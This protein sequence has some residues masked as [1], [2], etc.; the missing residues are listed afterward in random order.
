M[1][2]NMVF[3]S[4]GLFKAAKYFLRPAGYLFMY[5]VEYYLSKMKW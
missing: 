1:I 2:V 4:Q 5:G 3:F